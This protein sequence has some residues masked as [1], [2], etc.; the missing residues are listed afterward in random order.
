MVVVLLL[1]L[2]LLLLLAPVA[3]RAHRQS[4]SARLHARHAY[5][6]LG[7]TL[8]GRPEWQFARARVVP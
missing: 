7:V 6:G 8:L 5:V 4:A 3:G 1:L 2:L